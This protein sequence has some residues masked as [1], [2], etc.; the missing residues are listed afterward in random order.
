MEALRQSA[1][2]LSGTNGR[3][4]LGD[5]DEEE[6]GFMCKTGMFAA[7]GAH[8]GALPHEFAG[9]WRALDETTDLWDDSEICISLHSEAPLEI[10]AAADP[11]LSPDRHRC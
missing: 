10:N 3:W 2:Y 11:V 1:F 7:N 4:I 5:E 8:R 6:T 9:G